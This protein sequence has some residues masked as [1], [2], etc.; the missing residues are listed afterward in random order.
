MSH[1]CLGDLRCYDNDG[2]IVNRNAWIGGHPALF[3]ALIVLGVVGL[4]VGAI[5]IVREVRR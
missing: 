1:R 3:W 2:G 5:A 4:I